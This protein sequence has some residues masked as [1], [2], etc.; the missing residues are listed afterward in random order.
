MRPVG[1]VFRGV[2]EMLEEKR[3]R[4]IAIAIRI[5]LVMSLLYC[6]ALITKQ[7]VAAWYFRQYTS[8]GLAKAIQWDANNP[9]FYVALARLLQFAPDRGNP[10][11]VVR[12]HEIATFLSPY[13]AQYWAE[14]GAA[15]EWAGQ[16]EAA[17][18]A[19]KRAR[20]LFPNSPDIN[21]R[22]GNLYIR[23]GKTHEGLGALQKATI[24]DPEMRRHAF[25]LAWRTTGDNNLI[26]DEMLPP[27]TDVFFEYISYLIETHRI[28]DAEQTWHR[29]LGL[30]L[31]F[32]LRQAFTY[33]DA[34]IQH[35]RVDRL[36][37]AWET[38][39]H[40][41]PAE[42]GPQFSGPN[43]VTNGSFEFEILNG[44]LD[45]RVIPV[46]GVVVRVDSRIFFD[47]V[48]SLRI[49]FD[50][51]NNL[52]YFHVF[53][54]VPVK[55]ETLYRFTSNMRVQGVT[56]DSGPR[57]QICDAY[58]V[59]RLFLSTENRVGTSGWL[60]QQLEFRTDRDTRL[61]VLRVARSLSRKFDNQIAGTVWIDRL[62]LK[63]V[64]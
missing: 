38:L 61:L 40:H 59:G 49:E 30:R 15:Y 22:L 10:R 33:L 28:D 27:R 12:L 62:T 14:L 34:L 5:C 3:R 45:W 21:W 20:E 54:Y 18:S 37:A 46:K 56:S 19:V 36:V 29:V 16:I 8:E 23:T 31:H 9:Q 39:A 13:Q 25:E 57:F 52:E 24:E 6:L 60:P 35:Q 55:P 51:K 44:G 64:E 63:A 53:Q 48:R 42:I 4:N 7:G 11:E 1:K 47:G 41:Y 2:H 26:L 50:G 43:L 32:E 58:D 17:S